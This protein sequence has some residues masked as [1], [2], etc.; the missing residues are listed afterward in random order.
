MQGVF[1]MIDWK[2]REIEKCKGLLNRKLR[3]VERIG[4]IAYLKSLEK[5]E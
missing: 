4:L 5:K 2:E 1:E 3:D